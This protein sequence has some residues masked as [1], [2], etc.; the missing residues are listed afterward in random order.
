MQ[1]ELLMGL[2]YKKRL[3]ILNEATKLKIKVLNP[4]KIEKAEKVETKPKKEVEK[5]EKEKA[6][7][8]PKKEV[9]KVEKE[10]KL[11]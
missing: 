3:D 7:V 6:E 2:G 8:K 9:E 5:V 10:K 4:G 1:L 11:K